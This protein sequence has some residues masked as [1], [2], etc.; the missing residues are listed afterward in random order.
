MYVFA[1][2]SDSNQMRDNCTNWSSFIFILLPASEKR[3]RQKRV[4]SVCKQP[5]P[6][7]AGYRYHMEPSFMSLFCRKGNLLLIFALLHLLVLTNTMIIPRRL[8]TKLSSVRVSHGMPLIQSPL[9]QSDSFVASLLI[10]HRTITF[11]Q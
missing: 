9:H 1:G 11:F 2:S 10:I 5:I 3:S 4:L 8:M 7:E 6:F